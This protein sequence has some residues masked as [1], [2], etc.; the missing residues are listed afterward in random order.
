[1]L[2]ALIGSCDVTYFVDARWSK[3]L[4]PDQGNHITNLPP[5]AS[6]FVKILAQ[7]RQMSFA[8]VFW[9]PRI[10]LCLTHN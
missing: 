8:P 7:F 9:A 10:V 1:M 3:K 4:T 6:R 2:L 5:N